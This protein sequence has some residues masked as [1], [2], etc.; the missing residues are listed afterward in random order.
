M[1]WE[2]AAVSLV[3]A[4]D[5]T[6]LSEEVSSWIVWC[7]H[8]VWEGWGDTVWAC[9]LISWGRGVWL[10]WAFVWQVEVLKFSVH[11]NEEVQRSWEDQ[12]VNRGWREEGKGAM[13]KL[14]DQGHRPGTKGSWARPPWRIDLTDVTE[15]RNQTTQA[16]AQ[17]KMRIQGIH[18]DGPKAPS[19]QGHEAMVL[20]LHTWTLSC[21]ETLGCGNRKDGDETEE[22]VLLWGDGLKFM[23]TSPGL[24]F[25][26]TSQS[27]RGE[28]DLIYFSASKLHLN[29]L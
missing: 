27:S 28:N 16:L 21:R 12:R 19:P 29:V 20:C 4:G 10:T 25:M 24:K 13:Y 14:G 6:R 15:F 1:S 26:I 23:I 2:V 22:T 9:I 5:M 7:S 18:M 3:S 8:M 11:F 17:Q